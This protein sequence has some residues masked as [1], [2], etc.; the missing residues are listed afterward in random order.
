MDSF[1]C[2]LNKNYIDVLRTPTYQSVGEVVQN[3]TKN[4]IKLKS[5]VESVETNVNFY[6]ITRK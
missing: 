1:L 3:G 5:S 6:L 4:E 2:T